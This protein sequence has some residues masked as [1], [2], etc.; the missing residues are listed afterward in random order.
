MTQR[1]NLTWPAFMKASIEHCEFLIGFKCGVERD[2]VSTVGGCFIMR[3]NIFPYISNHSLYKMYCHSQH[4][5]HYGSIKNDTLFHV[6]QKLE[7]NQSHSNTYHRP[8]QSCILILSKISKYHNNYDH[9]HQHHGTFP[10]PC[11]LI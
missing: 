4:F 8:T 10:E 7:C 1:N 3:L 6:K 9:N 5:F 2:T 11:S